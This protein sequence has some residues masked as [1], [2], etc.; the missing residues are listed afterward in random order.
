MKPK[1]SPAPRQKSVLELFPRICLI[2]MLQLERKSGEKI[3]GE[4]GWGSKK[5]QRPVGAAKEI[6]EKKEVMEEDKTQTLQRTELLKPRINASSSN[7]RQRTRYSKLLQP[8][9][10]LAVNSLLFLCLEDC[11]RV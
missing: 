6:I 2:V 1:E 11:R 5:I 10:S 7:I 3:S 8:K 9:V 4:N